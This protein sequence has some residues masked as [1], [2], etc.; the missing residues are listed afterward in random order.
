MGADNVTDIDAAT[1]RARLS[2]EP[3][4]GLF[5]WVTHRTRRF[6]GQI[7]GCVGT[8]GYWQLTLDN[9]RYLAHRIAWMLMTG[10]SPTGRLIDHINGNPLD[11]RWTNLRLADAATNVQNMRRAHRDSR[12][13]VLGT[14]RHGPGYQ[15]QIKVC[16]KT[17]YLGTYPTKEEAHA[18]YVAA[19][20]DLHKGC[21]L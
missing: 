7:A 15:A 13:Q 5:R 1:V 20:R 18:V 14:R 9:R 17:H 2:Y 11:N 12:T 16:G 19:K 8:E 3:E 6:I 10:S 21:T 4:T